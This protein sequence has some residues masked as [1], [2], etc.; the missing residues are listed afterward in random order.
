MYFSLSH[1]GSHQ[2]KV[3]LFCSFQFFSLNTKASLFFIIIVKALYIYL[4]KCMDY[5]QKKGWP[6]L[7]KCIVV[8]K[9]TKEAFSTVIIKKLKRMNYKERKRK[10]REGPN[11][12]K[13]SKK[14]Y[15]FPNL[16]NFFHV[17]Q[18]TNNLEPE[19]HMNILY[20]LI[21]MIVNCIHFCYMFVLQLS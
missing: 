2:G 12:G 5:Y 9:L 16:V 21:I 6:E 17:L 1:Q 10:K 8:K 7:N 15:F 18:T 19:R 14:V 3:Y 20:K 13:H 4:Q 11:S